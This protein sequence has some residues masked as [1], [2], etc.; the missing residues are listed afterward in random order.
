MGYLVVLVDYFK[1]KSLWAF[2]LEWILL[3][4][5]SLVIFYFSDT[6]LYNKYAVDFQANIITALSILIGFTISTFTLLLTI[7]NQKINQAKKY[8]VGRKLNGTELSLYSCNLISF[9]Y[10]I[11]MQG[12]LLLANFIYP[13]F[14][15]LESVAGKKIFSLN[16]GFVLYVLLLLLKST[17]DFYFII[18]RKSDF[19]DDK[20]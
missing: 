15:N 9:G 14:V 7:D 2:F 12:F 1:S 18:T 6:A 16:I 11:F 13:V 20:L 4:L 17:L 10:L 19:K 3:C 8:L 5:A